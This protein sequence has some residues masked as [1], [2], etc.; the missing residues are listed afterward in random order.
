M[1]GGESLSQL[2]KNVQGR[3]PSGTDTATM[4]VLGFVAVGIIAVLVGT[5]VMVKGLKPSTPTVTTVPS[6]DSTPTTST[7][8]DTALLN[9]T[10]SGTPALG[11]QTN[12]LI[13]TQP[14]T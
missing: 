13:Q 7:S 6:T 2:L 1:K 12:P 5:F 10:S 9:Q 4:I 14:D 3:K 8:T 11:T